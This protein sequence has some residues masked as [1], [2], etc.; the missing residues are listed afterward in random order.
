VTDLDLRQGIGG[1]QAPSFYAGS[2]DAQLARVA[3]LVRRVATLEATLA[4]RDRRISHLE[5]QLRGR[6][7]VA[8][9]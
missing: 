6:P 1:V 3:A 5:L 7:F 9:A 2:A 8:G 4:A